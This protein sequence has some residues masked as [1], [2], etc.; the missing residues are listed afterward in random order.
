MSAPMKCE[1]CG[2]TDNLKW[3][4]EVGIA[5]CAECLKLATVGDEEDVL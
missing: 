1:N 3:N 4:F 2:A 5:L